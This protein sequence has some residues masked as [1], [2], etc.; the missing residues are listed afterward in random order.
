MTVEYVVY[1]GRNIPKEG[2]RAFVYSI[3]GQQKLVNS[4]AEYQTEIRSGL[5]FS[6]KEFPVEAQ[7]EKSVIENTTV[8]AAEH[9]NDKRSKKKGR[10]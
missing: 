4:W 7:Q 9:K 2:F 3:D 5:W 1:Q 6:K 8:K 10:K